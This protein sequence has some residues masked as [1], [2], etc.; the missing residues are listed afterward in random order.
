MRLIPS[1]RRFLDPDKGGT[2]GSSSPSPASAAKPALNGA[3]SD[4]AA[5]Q[6]STQQTQDRGAGAGDQGGEGEAGDG[7]DGVDD[8]LEHL[9]G[10]ELLRESADARTG[11]ED[12]EEEVDG[13]K[14]AGEEGE[15]TATAGDEQE[16]PAEDAW[17]ESL[18]EE[19][20]ERVLAMQKENAALKAKKPGADDKAKEE[21]AKETPE[22]KKAAKAQKVNPLAGIRTHEDLDAAIESSEAIQEWALENWDG[23]E[24]TLGEG[25]GATKRE[26]TGAEVRRLYH[27]Q[28][29]RIHKWAPQQARFIA[30]EAEASTQAAQIYPW[31]EK[32]D[33]AEYQIFEGLKQHFPD[34]TSRLPGWR[35]FLARAI[36]GFK[37]E[38]AR[39]KKGAAKKEPETFP[40]ETDPTAQE[41]PNPTTTER[42]PVTPGGGRAGGTK[43]ALN[44]RR[45]QSAF[46][47]ALKSGGSRE[48]IEALLDEAGF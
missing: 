6:Q 7:G 21:K 5:R 12:E 29:E 28:T 37:L 17:L 2:S 36:E 11:G 4:S 35:L 10:A 40:S 45:Q 13:G 41:E 30:K 20:R 23:G 3:A 14:K 1:V 16:T 43:P 33:S 22:G 31:L 24:L 8:L 9:P 15:E 25:E 47:L 27:A 38:Q 26:L 42:P 18:P 32:S 34:I 46:D 48:S 39:T 44:N 19:V